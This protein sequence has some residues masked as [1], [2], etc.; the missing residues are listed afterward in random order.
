MKIRNVIGAIAAVIALTIVLPVTAA[1]TT[2]PSPSP[3]PAVAVENVDGVLVA[4]EPPLPEPPKE[5]PHTPQSY[6]VREFEIPSAANDKKGMFKFTEN[7]EDIAT[8]LNLTADEI[9]Y[10]NPDKDTAN[11][12]AGVT[13]TVPPIHGVV[14]K[15]LVGDT[16]RWIADKWSVDDFIKIAQYNNI[17]DPDRIKEDTVI[18]VPDAKFP[19]KERP[20]LVPYNTRISISNGSANVSTSNSSF[21]SSSPSSSSASG[22]HFAEGYCTWWASERWHQLGRGYVPWFGNAGQWPA[23]ARAMG[24]ATGMTPRVGSIMATWE[25]SVGHVAIVESVNSDGSW[26]VSEENYKGL[27]IISS[28]TIRPGTVPLIA[29]IY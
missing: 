12:T 18:I 15:I 28:R 3:V 13:L 2:D 6:T 1:A 24:Y 7:L 16:L 11:L 19:P 4:D 21:S 25:S 23:G 22:N 20:V 9:K 8:T 17:S 29:F 14:Y 26:T 27:Y 10:S 5:V